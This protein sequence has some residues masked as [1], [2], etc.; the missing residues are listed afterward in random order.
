MDYCYVLF[1]RAGDEDK[2]CRM[3]TNRL[4]LEQFIPFVPKK[5]MVFKRNGKFSKVPRVC[6]PGYVFIKSDY[7]PAQFLAKMFPCVYPL[8]EVYRFLH[9]GNDRSDVAL[10]EN[11]RIQLYRLFGDKFIIDCVIG[12]MS[13]DRIQIISGPFV[14]IEGTVK[15]VIPRK[16]EV[17]VEIPIFG[18]NNQTTL[19]LD[20]VEKVKNDYSGDELSDG[21]IYSTKSE[22]KV[23]GYRQ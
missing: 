16:R 19:G 1:V 7:P 3:L 23:G 8:K 20:I 10:H 6:F 5:I 2:V 21:F 12:V 17:V 9:Y 13:G 11:E 15:K 18:G 14:G 4:G 22:M